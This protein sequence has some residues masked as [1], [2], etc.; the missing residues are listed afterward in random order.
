MI[1]Y[2]IKLIAL[3]FFVTQSGFGSVLPLQTVRKQKSQNC[4]AYAGSF[5]IE[6]RGL[7]TNG[8]Q[9]VFDLE[10][11]FYYQTLYLRLMKEYEN[12]KAWPYGPVDTELGLTSE[13]FEVLAQQGIQIFESKVT[14]RLP[15]L[16]YPQKVI[17]S[18]GHIKGEAYKISGKFSAGY[19]QK[20]FQA[21][22][23]A[24]A[25]EIIVKLIEK[26]LNYTPE[27]NTKWLGQEIS[28]VGV[29]KEIF[30]SDF[31][32][33]MSSNFVTV[34]KSRDPSNRN[35]LV[36]DGFTTA[37]YTYGQDYLP[38]VTRSLDNGW[39]V[40]GG[41]PGH[42]S[43]LIGY[44]DLGNQGI[45]FAEADSIPG[46]INWIAESDLRR[47]NQLT[48]YQ[49]AVKEFI[50][51]VLLAPTDSADPDLRIL[52]PNFKFDSIPELQLQG[53]NYSHP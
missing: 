30:K 16:Q 35:R 37:Y 11:E 8:H 39:A 44:V 9:F 43:A 51:E 53:T 31:D 19:K 5:M 25:H 24:E 1:K 45:F 23:K 50:P 22:S 38:M 34:M 26:R 7:Q 17:S 41:P 10:K 2:Y 49:P 15:D 20:L 40:G 14:S 33:R 12:K 13:F 48:F 6:S 21:K 28:K 32:P 36:N 4:W 27:S 52:S 47:H 42:A 3:T 46:E 29:A 18:Y